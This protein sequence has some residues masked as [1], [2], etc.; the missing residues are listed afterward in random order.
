MAL[1]GL[2]YGEKRIGVA[3]SDRLFITSQVVGYVP[4]DQ[5]KD[6]LQC[7]LEALLQSHKVIKIVVGL[8]LQLNGKDTPQTQKTRE[9]AEWLETVFPDIPVVL[10][11]ERFTSV[12]AN[13]ILIS[14]GVRRGKRK[15]KVDGL[16]AQIMLH[17]YMETHPNR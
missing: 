7:D 1:L 4:A 6:M 2:D 5:E 17:H 13:N 14:A 10:F 11:D 15:Q 16:A 8:P 12:S 9:F 3:A